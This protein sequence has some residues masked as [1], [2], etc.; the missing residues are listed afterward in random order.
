MVQYLDASPQGHPHFPIQS[1]IQNLE[2]STPEMQ[3][4]RWSSHPFLDGWQK[5][6]RR[7]H[8]PE[9]CSSARSWG[10]SE[11]GGGY[12]RLPCTFW[13]GTKAPHT[14][15]AR[16]QAWQEPKRSGQLSL[17]SPLRVS[18]ELRRAKLA[19]Q[20]FAIAFWK[21]IWAVSW[22]PGKRREQMPSS[23]SL[24]FGTG[25]Y[26]VQI[27]GII[28]TLFFFIAIS[29]LWAFLCSFFSC[30]CHLILFFF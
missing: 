11:A 9:H 26:L 12:Q 18:M 10:I 30:I 8:G 17:F 28:C 24:A 22:A 5:W 21:F 1:C 16:G 27:V 23:C 20:I 4:T 15:R 7:N 2:F 6:R 13:Q 19:G 29:L 14:H 25:R 3:A